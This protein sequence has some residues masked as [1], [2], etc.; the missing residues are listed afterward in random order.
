MDKTPLS[1]SFTYSI[2][3]VIEY[4]RM[5]FEKMFQTHQQTKFKPFWIETNII[6]RQVSTETEFKIVKKLFKEKYPHLDIYDLKISFFD[7]DPSVDGL[8][9]KVGL[10][11]F[12]LRSEHI[13]DFDYTLRDYFNS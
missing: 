9:D 10:Y 6:F 7:Y 12:G 11:S 2:L 1:F 13:H 4:I 3:N 8:K 5:Q